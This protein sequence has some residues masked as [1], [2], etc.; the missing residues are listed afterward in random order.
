MADM[1]GLVE[2][3]VAATNA[4]DLEALVDCFAEDYVNETPTH[5]RHGFHGREQVRRNWSTIFAAVPDIT[6]RVL[7]TA[8]EDETV[9][10][11]WEMSGTRRDGSPHLMRG[12]IV[13]VVHGGR[14]AS[15]RF[16]LE[17]VETSS[18]DADNAVHEATG[19]RP[20]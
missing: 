20:A 3:L 14:A 4:H 6:V 8:V 5:P 7:A 11:E 15:A 17:P 16:Y 19:G 2:R 9:W 12:V 18:G 13:F 1:P 10:T